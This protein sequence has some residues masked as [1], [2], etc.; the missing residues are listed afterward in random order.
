MRIL[1]L[2]AL[3]LTL[4]A[5][6]AQAHLARFCDDRL[7]LERVSRNHAWQ[8]DPLVSMSY[9]GSF[10][11]TTALSFTMIVTFT[12]PAGT[13]SQAQ[14]LRVPMRVGWVHVPLVIWPRSM[15]P[16]DSTSLAA[17]VQVTCR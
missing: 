5:G 13:T 3:G 2:L 1:T 9:V 4:S 16:T 7:R 17:G 6:A 14:A 12:G 11:N 15:E 8:G 10:I